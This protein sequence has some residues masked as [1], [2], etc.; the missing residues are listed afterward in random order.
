MTDKGN[1]KTNFDAEDIRRYLSGQMPDAERHA[2]EKEALEDPFLADAIEGM[3]LRLPVENLNQDLANLHTRLERRLETK[4]KAIV[5]PFYKIAAAA[6]LFLLAGSL[7]ILYFLNRGKEAGPD[8]MAGEISRVPASTE[9]IDSGITLSPAL[10][11]LPD[12]S[13]QSAP[14]TAMSEE[15]SQAM[16]LRRDQPSSGAKG[17]P[18]TKALKSRVRENLSDQRST[19]I[20]TKDEEMSRLQEDEMLGNGSPIPIKTDTL[21]LRGIAADQSTSNASPVLRSMNKGAE[22]T[23]YESLKRPLPVDEVLQGKVAGVEVNTKKSARRLELFSIEPLS[24]D[25]TTFGPV[26]SWSRYASVV[27][28]VAAPGNRVSETVLQF[29]INLQGQPQDL[30]ILRT[31]NGSKS[32]E[33]IRLIQNGPL[34]QV[35]PGVDS[36]V[37]V[38]IRF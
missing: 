3:E 30:K 26:S 19:R 13:T 8:T 10:P 12:T 27:N 9:K 15:G 31:E 4:Q 28:S 33:I 5:A 32:A 18:E 14:Q 17:L 29:R 23:A 6:I 25:T 20:I 2:L 21:R 35:K 16:A 7:S 38:L 36:T 24:S 1:D 34:W 22:Q 37:K 11:V